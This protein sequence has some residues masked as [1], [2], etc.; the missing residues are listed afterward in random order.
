[1]TT[2][3]KQFTRLTLRIPLDISDWLKEMSFTQSRSMNG[4][5]VE[6]LKKMKEE[7]ENIHA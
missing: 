7:D 3:T 4:Q 6:Y 5:V 2:N 1:M